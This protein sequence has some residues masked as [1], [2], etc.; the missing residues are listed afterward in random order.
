MNLPKKIFMVITI[1][2]MS[3][4]ICLFYYN[5]Y[6]LSEIEVLDE[7]IDKDKALKVDDDY[8]REEIN[9]AEIIDVHKNKFQKNKY[10]YKKT[11]VK[12]NDYVNLTTYEDNNGRI[13]RVTIE[14]KK[15]SNSESIVHDYYFFYEDT[16]LY[17][18]P[19]SSAIVTTDLF[20]LMN[21]D[22]EIKDISKNQE[23]S[24][25]EQYIEELKR[26]NIEYDN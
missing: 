13:I 22:G 2:V 5:S 3:V 25:I 16:I 9:Y 18:G 26:Y 21:K 20:V 23:L 14:Q 24:L 10:E 12:Y 8:R 15:V 17:E 4:V 19:E 1:L 7:L 6:S 11:V